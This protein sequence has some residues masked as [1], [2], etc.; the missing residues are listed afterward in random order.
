MLFVVI[1]SCCCCCCCCCCIRLCLVSFSLSADSDNLRAH[2]VKRRPQRSLYICDWL[3]FPPIFRRSPSGEYFC[4]F[5]LI[6]V[7]FS[8]F[9]PYPF[10]CVCVCVH[11]CVRVCVRVRV[12]VRA[13]VFVCVCVCVCVR[14]CVCICA[15]VHVLWVLFLVSRLTRVFYILHSRIHKA[16]A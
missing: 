4:I 13:C 6:N 8:F 16:S 15:C 10:V 1:F 12:R 7:F 5:A 3:Y 14:V 9:S 11:M 2:F